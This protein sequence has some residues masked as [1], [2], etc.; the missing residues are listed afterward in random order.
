MRVYVRSGMALLLALL[1]VG[2]AVAQGAKPAASK[3][4]GV[5]EQFAK[6]REQHK[7]TF[8]LTRMLHQMQGLDRNPKYALSQT[9]AKKTLAIVKPLQAKPK[10]TQSQAKQATKQLNAILTPTQRKELAKTAPALQVS[11]GY[12]S[13]GSRP[14]SFGGPHGKLPSSASKP[15]GRVSSP[16][17]VDL[18]KMKDFNPFYT[19]AAKSDPRQA[20][21]GRM[22]N[23][24]FS[25]LDAKAKGVKATSKPASR[26]ATA[27]KSAR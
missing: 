21:S 17:K 18:N 3:L 8:E 14:G 7:H 12:R 19:K 6:F 23:E 13:Q 15:A 25:K 26:P 1:V 24:F 2:G 16:Q 5:S 10:L 20:Q 11:S 22:W 4:S 27:A 9:Q